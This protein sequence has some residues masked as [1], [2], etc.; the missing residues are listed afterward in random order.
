MERGWAGFTVLLIGWT[1]V[2]ALAVV[3]AESASDGDDDLPKTLRPISYADAQPPASDPQITPRASSP[4]SRPRSSSAAAR[5]RLTAVPVSAR[6]RWETS[7]SGRRIGGID[8]SSLLADAPAM[9]GHFY[10]GGIT[11]LGTTATG[12]M[13]LPDTVL[14]T[15]GDADVPLAGGCG[16][17]H[18]AENNK[19]LTHDRIYVR[20]NRYNQASRLDVTY[21]S[22]DSDDRRAQRR[23]T[24][25]TCTLAAEKTFGDG[26]WS[27]EARMPFAGATDFQTEQVDLEYGSFSVD[28][29]SV[30]NMALILKRMMRLDARGSVVAGLGVD[31]PTGS[32]AKGH[33]DL[34][35]YVI[36]NDAVH[37]LPYAGFLIAPT[38]QV[39]L[40]GFAQLDVPLNG[41]RVSVD[42]KFPHLFPEDWI[43]GPEEIGRYTEQTLL[44]LD[45]SLGRWVVQDP[46]SPLLTGFAV[47]GELH[48]TT[49]VNDSDSVST[50]RTVHDPNALVTTHLWFANPGN[51]VDH[52]NLTLG[53]HTEWRNN[54]IARI[55]SVFPL[56]LGSDRPFATELQVQLERRF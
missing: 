21:D 5:D 7:S 50:S 55:G 33:V 40:Q 53:L 1:L 22:L 48:Y 56:R 11:V 13:L 17:T 52:M 15:H 36:H 20:F 28:G 2:G 9:L 16:R 38:N 35:E 46:G 31:L 3:R 10:G 43:L 32:S 25:D 8:L 34:T 29:G 23:S 6:D 54:T 39:F 19:A 45:L 26:L 24:I 51:R 30:G 41:Q 12:G 27:L 37:F 44:H 49:T 4:A 14:L 47:I 42:D 18:V